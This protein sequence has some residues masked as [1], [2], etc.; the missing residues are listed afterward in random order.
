[1]ADDTILWKDVPEAK[2]R[3]YEEALARVLS[4]L[5][6]TLP[7]RPLRKL[8]GR[9]EKTGW[10]VHGPGG[11]PGR[12]TIDVLLCSRRRIPRISVCSDYI[13][14]PG[15]HVLEY[16]LLHELAHLSSEKNDGNPWFEST[17]AIFTS[18]LCREPRRKQRWFALEPVNPY[19]STR[20]LQ[21]ETK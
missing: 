16:I 15:D 18:C 2:A 14:H 3:A 13:E 19:D 7:A 5:W 11:P 20:M 12:L 1:M 6:A 21:K 17:L 4:K 9:T 10:F 8:F